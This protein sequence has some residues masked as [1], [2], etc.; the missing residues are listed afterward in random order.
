MSDVWCEWDIVLRS[1]YRHFVYMQTV[2]IQ[3]LYNINKEIIIP[4]EKNNNDSARFFFQ[5]MHS[6]NSYRQTHVSLHNYK[7]QVINRGL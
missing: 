3:L 5:T 6:W 4:T 1:A 7:P 2:T